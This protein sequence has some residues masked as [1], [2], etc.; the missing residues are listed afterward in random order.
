MAIATDAYW[1]LQDFTGSLSRRI[2]E[3]AARQAH[4]RH[5]GDGP[6]KVRMADVL[7]SAQALLPPALLEVERLLQKET[8]H[9]RNAS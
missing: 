5:R 2:L 9:V 4:A 6:G 8:A 7:R 3:A 1:F